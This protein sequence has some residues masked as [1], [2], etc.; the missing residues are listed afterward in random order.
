MRYYFLWNCKRNG[1]DVKKVIKKKKYC[2]AFVKYSKS[3]SKRSTESSCS[4]A[5]TEKAKLGEG[6]GVFY[7]F[8]TY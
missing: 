3:V 4:A 7:Y 2:L 5:G 6:G 1:S 8:A